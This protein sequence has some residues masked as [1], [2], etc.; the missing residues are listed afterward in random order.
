MVTRIV[1]HVDE[2][3]KWEMTLGNLAHVVGAVDMTDSRIE[4]V[5]NGG[6]VRQY[7]GDG[8]EAGTDSMKRLAAAGVR[9]TA[10]RNA[11][12]G[13]GIHAEQ[14]LPFVEVVPSGVLELAGRQAEG[15]AYIRP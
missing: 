11:L 6:A 13:F 1:F 15:Y 2:S 3:K 4:V 5:A 12:V 7:L 9:F 14:L 10:C 8:P